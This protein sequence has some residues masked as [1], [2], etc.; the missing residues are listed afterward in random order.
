M[1]VGDAGG[2]ERPA[3]AVVS[4]FEDVRGVV[5]VLVTRGRNVGGLRASCGDGSIMLNMHHSPRFGGVIAVQLAPASRVI[6]SKPSS[7]PAQMTPGSCGDSARVYT[8]AKCSAPTASRLMGPPEGFKVS[9]SALVKSGTDLLP[10]LPLVG[11]PPEYLIAADIN[12]VAI[13]GR[14]DDG[15]RSRRSGTCPPPRPSQ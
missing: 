7:E 13:V 6:C 9:G 2:D 11:R 5:I 14:K 8:V 10:A 15:G 4:R 12:N 3:I 1:I